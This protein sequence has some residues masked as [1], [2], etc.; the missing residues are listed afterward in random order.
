MMKVVTI[1]LGYIGLPTALTFAR[2]GA[3]VIGVDIS[4]RTIQ[5]LNAGLV[6]IEEHGLNN[7]LK[8][9]LE[10][11]NFRASL[12]PEKGDV[13][14]VAVPTPNLQDQFGSCDL[15]YVEQAL[16]S[17]LPYLE[18]GNTVIIEST[19]A[20]RTME[21]V[22]QPFFE[23]AG[24]IIGEDLFLVHCPE[25][26]LPGKIL[27]EL[28]F[29]N[30]IIGGMTEKCTKKGKEI[31]GLFVQGELLEASASVAELSKLMENTFR[32]VNIAL[33][34]ELVKIGSK[35]NIDAL[36][37]IQM[38]NKHPR[39]N[40]HQPGPGVGGHCLAVD[41]YFI[42]AK[43]PE[44]T[45]LIQQARQINKSMPRFVAVKALSILHENNGGVI[46]LLGLAYK[47][48]I[49]DMRESP[50][51]EVLNELQEL[52]N[53]TIQVFDPHI[54]D[55]GAETLEEVMRESDLAV[56]LCDHDEFKELPE[57]AIDLMNHKVVFDTKKIVVNQEK[58]DQYYTLGNLL[59]ESEETEMGAHYE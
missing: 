19:I 4:E 54:N 37:V 22:I 47:G 29:N 33:A 46:T 28:I 7:F 57:K 21:D 24:F 35:L 48:N 5:M 49:D 52:S 14:I 2:H 9:A 8:N 51:V 42:I 11:K 59:T 38:A 16:R 32:D 13:F 27:H 58:F 45:S 6:P 56:I 12:V 43:A 39:V 53:T 10:K 23:K 36:E 34:N 15:H 3:E 17:I 55:V 18:K 1:G 31:Y 41:P 50:A 40:I 20:P 26:V 25:R 30:R 44:E